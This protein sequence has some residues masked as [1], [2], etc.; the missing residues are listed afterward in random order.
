MQHVQK[1]ILPSA[2]QN[3]GGGGEEK[4]VQ[5]LVAT[6][7]LTTVA[8]SATEIPFLSLPRAPCT[9]SVQ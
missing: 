7:F 4:K 5:Y 8:E 1:T 2:G 3:P 9:R 6:S